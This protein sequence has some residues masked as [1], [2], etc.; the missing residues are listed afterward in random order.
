VYQSATKPTRNVP[1]A[2]DPANEVRNRPVPPLSPFWVMSD[3]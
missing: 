1:A 3:S 2:P